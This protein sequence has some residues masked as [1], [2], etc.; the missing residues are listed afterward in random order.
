MASKKKRNAN[1]PV[2]AEEATV[3]PLP[4]EA[5]VLAASSQGLPGFPL[6]AWLAGF[7]AALLGALAVY[8]PA[9]RGE[10]LFDDI[11]LPFRAIPNYAQWTALEAM[12]GVRPLTSLSYWI[13]F[14]TGGGTPLAFHVTSVLLHAGSAVLLAFVLMRVLALRVPEAPERGLLATLGA[15]LF[16]LHPAQTEAVAYITSHSET[17]SMFF[18]L[19][20]LAVFLS[21]REARISW[22][23][24]V[25]TLACFL[26]A[27][28]SKEHALTLPAVL[29][30]L[31]LL[32][33]RQTFPGLLREGWRLYGLLAGGAAVGV[34][35]VMNT[36]AGA[37][38]AGFG[39]SD[40]QWW[41]YMLTQG[42]AIA[43]YLRLWLLPVGQNGDYLF[44][45]S[46]GPFEHG[47][48][49]FWVGL[50]ALGYA[51]YR[52]RE[53]A[54]L[55]TLGFVLFLLVLAPTS[56]ILPIQDAA[57]ERR[58]YLASLGLVMATIGL[59]LRFQVRDGA[60][61]YG[62][63]ALLLVLAI[64]T[65][66]RSQVW[67]SGNVFWADVLQKNPQSWRA[68]VA[69]GLQALERQQC[70]VA[71]DRLEAARFGVADNFKAAWHL[72][73]ARAL[74]CVGR[75]DEA[76]AAYLDSL[77]VERSASALSQLGVHY[78][79]RERYDEALALMDEAVTRSPGFPLGWSNRGNVHA[80]TGNCQQAIAD[81]ERALQLMPGNA[82]AQRG[83]AFC[84][85]QLANRPPEP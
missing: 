56:S 66:S 39:M 11:A 25:G 75:M 61:R 45:I 17:L 42:R 19:A 32:V 71:V 64:T 26:L 24:A 27:M 60:L 52:A 29:V 82:N 57:V 20:A 34:A 76:E 37:K 47:A 80:R 5:A 69:V 62:G 51:A 15:A 84:R 10:F 9:L 41:E 73:Y 8:S 70:S 54:P 77:A 13:S 31:D 16:L 43:L 14:H 59:L 65:F 30:V 2:L 63:M 49:F 79:R 40:L 68:N 7:G 44:P 28:L 50:A 38:T 21:R 3:S 81:F 85:E 12:K 23:V 36:L 18:Y 6:W 33:Y 72:N 35:V 67:A 83:L 74:E 58:V 46:R 4:G 22:G 78:G 1:R 55:V 53:R 48:I